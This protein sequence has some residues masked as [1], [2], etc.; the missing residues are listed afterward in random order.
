MKKV[1]LP[2]QNSNPN[3]IGSWIINPLSVCDELIAYFEANKNKQNVGVTAG[4]KN[5]NIKNS[6]DIVMLPKEL[7]LP[8]NEIFG[9]YFESL[10]SCYQ[11]YTEQW[12]FLNTFAENLEIG[13]FNLQRYQGGQHFSSEHA[14]RTS[15]GTIHRVF[16]W[17]TYLND[18][19]V[20]DGGTTSFG[21]YGLEIQ[22]K[23][24]LTIIWPVEWTHAHRGNVLGAKSKYIITGWMHFPSNLDKKALTG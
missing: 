9:K 7:K 3:F 22:P 24:G 10:F 6:I 8:G 19:R 17:M 5:L 18:V 2:K 12:P 23:K 11:N 16:A 1:T 14:E 21:H 13:E 15:L 20:E 4:G